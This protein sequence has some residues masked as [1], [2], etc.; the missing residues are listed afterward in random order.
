[1]YSASIQDIE[2]MPRESLGAVAISLEAISKIGI[3]FCGKEGE[4]RP[5]G[6]YPTIFDLS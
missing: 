3:W 4:F 1:M 2:E 6:V 5:E